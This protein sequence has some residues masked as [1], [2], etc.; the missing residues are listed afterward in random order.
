MA[1]LAFLLGTWRA[2]DKYEKTVLNPNGGEGSGL[3][4]TMV[5]PGGFSLL[6]DYR[7]DAPHGS[8]SGHQLFAWEPKQACFVGYLVTSSFPGVLQVTGNWEG[9]VLVLSGEFEIRGMHIGFRQTFSDIKASE[10]VLRQYNS[11]DD[12]VSQLFGTTI[13]SKQTEG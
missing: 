7:Y 11:I 9:P 13:L 3:Y 2:M 5:G 8:S 6:T 12:G 10:I 4:K 1:S